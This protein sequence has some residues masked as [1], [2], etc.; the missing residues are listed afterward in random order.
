M[1]PLIFHAVFALRILRVSV[2][3]DWSESVFR[4]RLLT[5]P[6]LDATIGTTADATAVSTGVAV[7][8]LKSEIS[9][10][11]E[12]SLRFRNRRFDANLTG[13]LIDYADA[14][15]RQTLIL[16]PGAV[17]PQLGSQTITSQNR[18][19]GDFCSAF[20]FPG[21]GADKFSNTRL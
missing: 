16:P 10:N 20:D 19:W 5:L 6:N 1:R 13:F 7:A 2:R 4:F 9:N 18:K 14:I 15:V 21:F 11:Y 3:S 12:V 17:G 8:P